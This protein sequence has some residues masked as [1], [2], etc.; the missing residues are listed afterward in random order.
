MP[1]PVIAFDIA[2]VVI[3]LVFVW[4]GAS[5]G[6][7]LAL[8]GFLAVII[9][10]TGASFFAATLSPKVGAALEPKF[11]AAIEKRLDEEIQNN[12]PPQSAEP[13]STPDIAPPDHPLPDVL[14][15]L[16][17][18][19]LYEDLIA[20]IDKAVQDGMTNVAAGAAAAVAAAIAQSVA[21][22]VLFLLAFVA[23]LVLWTLLSHGLNLVTKLPGLHFLNKSGGAVLGLAK[24]V[25]LLF[26][27]AWVL[28][29]SGILLPEETVAQT[30]LLKFFLETNPVTLITGV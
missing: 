18:M 4:R 17:D 6:F 11:A 9:A 26:V 3:L 19:G 13:G 7:V 15:V 29:F 21:Y 16:R 14:K 20:T 24:G 1:I 2:I 5:K 12:H 23:I 8:C 25:V 28:R 27:V 22:M 30:H 10:F